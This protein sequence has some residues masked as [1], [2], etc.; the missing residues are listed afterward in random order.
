MCTFKILSKIIRNCLNQLKKDKLKTIAI[1][2]IGSGNLNFPA[3]IVAL[4]I[5]EACFQF[6]KENQDT[7]YQINIVIYEK[8]FD[9]YEV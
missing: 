8:D 6:L 5:I 9:V 3:N 4:V 7:K 2:A 1:P